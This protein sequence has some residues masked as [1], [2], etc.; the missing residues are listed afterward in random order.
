LNEQVYEDFTDLES[1][2]KLDKFM[3]E[4]FERVEKV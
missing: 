1:R 2:M 4:K 3:V